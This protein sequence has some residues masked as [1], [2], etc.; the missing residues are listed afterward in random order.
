MLTCMQGHDGGQVA[1]GWRQERLL[2]ACWLQVQR[3]PPSSW[4]VWMHA[5]PLRTC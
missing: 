2:V 5:I 3:A 4:T 1:A